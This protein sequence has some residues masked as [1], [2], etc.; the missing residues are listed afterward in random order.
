MEI[1][2]CSERTRIRGKKCSPVD[3]II[4]KLHAGSRVF[5]SDWQSLSLDASTLSEA[6]IQGVT[7]FSVS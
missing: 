5:S 2:A 7:L 1:R 4:S 6:R 3:L